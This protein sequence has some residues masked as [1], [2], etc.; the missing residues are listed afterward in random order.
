V[1][2]T[3]AQRELILSWA[4]TRRRRGEV[5]ERLPSRFLDELP[6]ELL[7]WDDAEARNDSVGQAHLDN[8]RTL[9]G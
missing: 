5:V 6:A 3:R 4:R 2:I 1:G 7:A 9:L 8:I